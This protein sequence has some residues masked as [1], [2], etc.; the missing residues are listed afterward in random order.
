MINKTLANAYRTIN[1]LTPTVKRPYAA[2][3]VECG[4]I[5]GASA[6]ENLLSVLNNWYTKNTECVIFQAKGKGWIE[7][8]VYL[9]E[10]GLNPL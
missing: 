5:I 3:V 8:Y 4:E 7:G 6:E 9:T 1:A 2:V 10:G